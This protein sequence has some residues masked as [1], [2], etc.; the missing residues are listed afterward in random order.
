MRLPHPGAGNALIACLIVAVPC[1]FLWDFLLLKKVYFYFD[2][3]VQW[4][5]IHEFVRTALAANESVLWNPYV[6]LGFPQ[7]AES[8]VGIFYPP[9]WLMHLLPRQEYGIA[10]SM[11]VHLTIAFGSTYL[12]ARACR[13]GALPSIY[14]A[15]CFTFSGF[16]F[17]QADNYNTVLVASYLPLKLLLLTRYFQRDD[18]RYLLYF[19][20][21]LGVE[22]LVCHANLTF[23]TTFASSLYFFVLALWRRR[24]PARDLAF[25]T[26]GTLLAALVAAVQIA[27]TYEL[28]TQSWRAGG[29]D[30]DSMTSFS[31][32]FAQYLTSFFPMMYGVNSIGYN[33]QD[34]FQELY[35]Y[36]SI[37]GL[38][39][40][41]FGAWRLLQRRDNRHLAVIALVGAAGFILSLG[42]NNP[43]DIFRVLVHVPGFNLFRCPG[44]WSVLLTLGLAMLA[45]YGLQVLGE[46][47]KNGRRWRALLIMLGIALLLPLAIYGMSLRETADNAALLVK[48]TQPLNAYLDHLQ[49]DEKFMY[50]VLTRISPL[51]YLLCMTALLALIFAAS[52]LRLPAKY[53]TLAIVAVSF[54]DLLFVIRPL[55]PRADPDFFQN[56]PWH[57]EY[58]QRNAGVFRATSS[59]EVPNLISVNNYSGAFH[60][61]QSIRGYA[62]IKIR[63]YIR[64]EELL[65][66]QRTDIMDYAGVKYEIVPNGDDTFRVDER[67]GA[68]PRAFLLDRYAV[69]PDEGSAFETFANMGLENWKS[70]AVIPAA[71]AHALGLAEISDIH[72]TGPETK[73]R[74]VEITGYHHASVEM[75]TVTDRPAFL[76]LTDMFYPGWRARVNGREVPIVP[77]Q[78]V[79]RGVYLESPGAFK[80]EMVYEPLSFKVG[81]AGSILGVMLLAAAGFWIRRRWPR[82]YPVAVEPGRLRLPRRPLQSYRSRRGYS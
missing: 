16:M 22:L 59:D 51:V 10:L 76:I 41:L 67:P 18:P 26:I 19:T 8:Q 64:V 36:M 50:T 46:E 30:Y 5:P 11:Y 53:C 34:Y 40:G 33:G 77:V 42:S 82:G 12:L 2:F 35:F 68:F 23:I 3:E 63:N 52:A 31:L 13:L 70:Y 75:R 27:P 55:H 38:V 73:V 15:L 57:I 66:Q 29:M 7:H 60:R 32:S 72:G 17:A 69:T 62:P 9:N 37:F 44:R 58:L 4:I 6:M 28:T 14:A 65:Y 74:P 25:F 49:P 21:L 80:V 48:I 45:G 61:I 56:R 1:V 47:L 24:A 81:A 39:L 20:L 79:F 78:G 54:L 71:S 43:L